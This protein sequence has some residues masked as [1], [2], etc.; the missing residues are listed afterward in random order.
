MILWTAFLLG[1]VGSAHCAGMCGPLTLALPQGAKQKFVISRLLYNFGRITTYMIMGAVFGLLGR[2]F[3]VVG[4]QRATSLGL[5][6]LILVCLFIS[7]RL[8]HQIP[9]SSIVGWLKSK[10][11]RLFKNGSLSSL[12]VIGLLNGLLPC[13]LVYT[14]CATAIA[15]DGLLNGVIYMFVFGLGTIPLLLT[16]ALLGTKL[17]FVLRF[18]LQRLV[19][20]TMAIVGAL[21]LFRGLALGIPY[22]SPQLAATPDGPNQCCHRN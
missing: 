5:G 6:A 21:L 19:P 8:L 1:F 11:S 16:I 3:S 18:K 20:A 7:P 17:Q 15:T 22:L 2:G 9:S 13:G 10:L 14:A 4:L 12:F